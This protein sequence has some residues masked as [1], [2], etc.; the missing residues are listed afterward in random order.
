MITIPLSKL[1]AGWNMCTPYLDVTDVN[2]S[3]YLLSL[4]LRALCMLISVQKYILKILLQSVKGLFQEPLDH[5][6][7]CLYSFSCI[8]HAEFKYGNEN[9]NCKNFCKKSWKIVVC[10]DSHMDRHERVN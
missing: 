4:K 8:F 2:D 9:L 10:F 3:Y 5:Y 6:L 7:A 1:V